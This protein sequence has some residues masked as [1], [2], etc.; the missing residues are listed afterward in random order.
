M[1][2]L[3]IFLKIKLIYKMGWSDFIGEHI[4]G[5]AVALIIIVLVYKFII[6]PISNEGKSVQD[7]EEEQ[8]D[9]F[10]ISK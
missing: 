4:F 9:S 5:I 3:L 7:L 8:E 1:D 10:F 2:P 6:Q